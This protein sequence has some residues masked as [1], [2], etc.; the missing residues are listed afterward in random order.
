MLTRA[1]GYLQDIDFSIGGTE[2]G[3]RRPI[4]AELCKRQDSRHIGPT[5]G[6]SG[7]GAGC[8]IL[9]GYYISGPGQEPAPETRLSDL[10]HMD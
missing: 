4:R 3:T 10:D 9:H 7:C 5:S 6:S 8:T 2:H 1:G